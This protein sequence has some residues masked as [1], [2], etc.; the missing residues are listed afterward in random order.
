MSRRRK[1]TTPEEA[2]AA[3][4]EQKKKYVTEKY[5]DIL[6]ERRRQERALGR[7]RETLGR[8]QD[9]FSN[10]RRFRSGASN[11]DSFQ[12]QSHRRHSDP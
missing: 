3:L 7:R 5:L 9:R 6:K 8:R 10:D 1:Y 12:H 4:K 2:K 11:E